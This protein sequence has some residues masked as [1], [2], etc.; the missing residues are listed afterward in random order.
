MT[1]AIIP[2]RFGSARFRGKP[3]ALISGKSMIQR[4][5]EQ[6]CKA[7]NITKVVIATDDNKIF[8]AVKSFGGEVVMTS[9]ELRSGTDRVAEAANILGLNP[10]EIV[11]NIQGDQPVFNSVVLDELITPFEDNDDIEM[12]TLGFK[13][14]NK[15]E[16][17][18]PKDV[19][20]IFDRNNFAIYFSRAQIPY[21]RDD[22]IEPDY[23]KHL[24]FYAYKKSFLDKVSNLDS[25]QYENIE[26]LEQLRVLEAGFKIK[27]SITEYDAPGVDIPE[28]IEKIE[29]YLTNNPDL[30]TKLD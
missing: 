17:T 14:I 16:I 6:A 7:K 10:D 27:I 21:L 23:Y 15:E 18:N 29:Q 12:A 19:K 3:L 28:D 13:I 24:G 2:S 5:Y 1:T 4:V 11:V 30:K 26:K 9:T 25:G 22:D 8:D 20:V